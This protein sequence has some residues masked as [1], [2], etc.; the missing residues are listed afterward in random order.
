MVIAQCGCRMLLWSQWFTPWIGWR[1]A[2]HTMHLTIC[3]DYHGLNITNLDCNH[4][5]KWY[6]AWEG[7]LSKYT[8]IIK[9]GGPVVVKL[10]HKNIRMYIKSSYLLVA[11]GSDSN[12]LMMNI[13][14]ISTSMALHYF[15]QLKH[16]VGVS[17]NQ[18]T[19]AITRVHMVHFNWMTMTDHTPIK[20]STVALTTH[21]PNRKRL[22]TT[23]NEW[24]R[25]KL[26]IRS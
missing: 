19:N 7:N 9:P 16:G 13:H 25:Y 5:S 22:L 11:P 6:Q 2:W 8:L 4:I 17:T 14:L 23:R 26:E 21:S 3:L 20:N 15:A 12:N 1:G 10:I 24:L 18:S